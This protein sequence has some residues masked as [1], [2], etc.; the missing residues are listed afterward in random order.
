MIFRDDGKTVEREHRGVAEMEEGKRGGEDQ[1]RLAFDEDLESADVVS[2]FS[3]VFE[4][5]CG[6]VVD[7]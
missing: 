6:G 7:R 1:E 2:M 5:A 3:V 4:T